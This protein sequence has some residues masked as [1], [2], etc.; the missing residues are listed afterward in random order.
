[1]RPATHGS[2]DDAAVAGGHCEV[3]Q[4]DACCCLDGGPLPC[5]PFDGSVGPDGRPKPPETPWP[6]YHPVPTRPMLGPTDR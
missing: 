5:D 1:V 6:R 3:C 2:F 4:P